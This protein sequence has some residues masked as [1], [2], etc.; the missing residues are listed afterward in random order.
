MVLAQPTTSV[1]AVTIAGVKVIDDNAG[2][3]RAGKSGHEHRVLV[4]DAAQ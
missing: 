1:T 3:E 2:G 4:F